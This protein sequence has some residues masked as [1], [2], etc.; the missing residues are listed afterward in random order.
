MW[1]T[2]TGLAQNESPELPL[3]YLVPGFGGHH[4]TQHNPTFRISFEIGKSVAKAFTRTI[5]LEFNEL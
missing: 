2:S 3:S 5:P 1:A 4:K